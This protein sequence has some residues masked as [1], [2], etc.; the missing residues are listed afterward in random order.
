MRVSIN[1]GGREV[2]IDCP[3]TN[4]SVTDVAEQALAVWR[5]TDG[6]EKGTEGPAFGFRD[7]KRWTAPVSPLAMGNGWRRMDEVNT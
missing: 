2:Q 3:D 5:A 6:A 4:T 1:A 7:D